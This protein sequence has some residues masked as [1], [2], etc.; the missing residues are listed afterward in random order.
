[1]TAPCDRGS[2]SIRLGDPRLLA[3]ADRPPYAAQA[4]Y[5][6][7]DFASWSNLISERSKSSILSSGTMFGPSDGA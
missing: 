3:G 6:F 4:R 1:M 2:C 7:Y 5:R